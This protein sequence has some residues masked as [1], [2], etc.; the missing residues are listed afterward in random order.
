MPDCTTKKLLILA[1]TLVDFGYVI[2]D[3]IAPWEDEPH[4]VPDRAPN[5]KISNSLTPVNGA[6][7]IKAKSVPNPGP[8]LFNFA[9]NTCFPCYVYAVCTGNFH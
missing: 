8:G 4:L 1:L 5:Y 9:G 3:S 7:I 6:R 2:P